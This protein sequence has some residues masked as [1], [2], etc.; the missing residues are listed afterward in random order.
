MAKGQNTKNDRPAR[1]FSVSCNKLFFAFHLSI[2]LV[3][4]KL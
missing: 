2:V 1:S 4:E 3:L